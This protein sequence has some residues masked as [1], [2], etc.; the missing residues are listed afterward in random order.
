MKQLIKKILK[1]ETSMKDFEKGMNALMSA[2]RVDYPFVVGYELSSPIDRY[3]YNIYLYILVDI[4]SVQ[5][6]YN[7]PFQEYYLT[8]N[9]K[10]YAL[11]RESFA[12]PFAMLEMGFETKDQA[13]LEYEKFKDILIESYELIPDD[14]KITYQMIN[15]SQITKNL[16]VD[17]F[18]FVEL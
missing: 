14:F 1:E 11:S 4:N 2:I 10:D 5:K 12:Y 17:G 13:F 18:K 7:K 9:G 3:K 15:G 16:N 6:F 8:P